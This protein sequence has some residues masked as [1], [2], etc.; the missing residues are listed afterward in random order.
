MSAQKNDTCKQLKILFEWKL[1]LNE[2]CFFGVGGL[3]ERTSTFSMKC[4]TVLS[5]D[6]S[7]V[8]F[9][10]VWFYKKCTNKSMGLLFIVVTSIIWIWPK[11]HPNKSGMHMHSMGCHVSI[12]MSQNSLQSH[13]EIAE[14]NILKL[15]MNYSLY[16]QGE[17]QKQHLIDILYIHCESLFKLFPSISATHTHTHRRT[18]IHTRMWQRRVQNA[19]N[20][21]P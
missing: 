13:T 6:W 11:K 15:S 5:T 1:C 2:V 20:K 16:F 18:H 21:L 19:I 7:C 8:F 12:L 10:A 4:L 14:L 3:Q 9:A 17:A